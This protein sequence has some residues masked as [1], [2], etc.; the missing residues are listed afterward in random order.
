[1]EQIWIVDNPLIH[2]QRCR[3]VE[4]RDSIS[5]H[6]SD[7]DDSFVTVSNI[8][9]LSVNRSRDTTAFPR[10]IMNDGCVFM[11]IPSTTTMPSCDERSAL[12]AK[13]ASA[14]LLN[15]N[16]VVFQ[17]WEVKLIGVI[18]PVWLLSSKA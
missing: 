2:R 9:L 8:D 18:L 17:L 6:F 12:F 13:L 3:T 16:A 14:Y 11:I 15:T 1:M 4:S 7:T 5:K 10:S